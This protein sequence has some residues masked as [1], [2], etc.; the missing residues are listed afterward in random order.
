MGS[1]GFIEIDEAEFARIKTARANLFEILLLEEN[2]DLVTEN[3]Q[4]YE[5][6]LLLIASRNMVFNDADDISMSRERIVVSRR[7][8]NLLSACRMYLDQSIHHLNNIYG[9]NSDKA[10]AAKGETTSQ[11]S[12]NFGYRAMEAL[13]NYIQHRGFPIHSIMFLS[14]WID[15]DDEEKSRMHH[16]VIPRIKVAELASDGKFNQTVLKEM[17]LAQDKHGLDIRPLIREYVEGIGKIH[18]KIREIVR[19]DLSGWENSINNAFDR[20]EKEYGTEASR[21]GLAIV[22]EQDDKHRAERITLFKEFTKRRQALNNKNI[23]F[24]NLCKRYASNEVR[25]KDA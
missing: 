22:A 8:V 10:I 21:A 20:F 17:L 1:S 6:E 25:K 4:E 5:A 12:H 15:I 23:V 13:R 16:S 11:H 9:E 18:E 2:L 7:I 14:E 24:A 3:F 19:A